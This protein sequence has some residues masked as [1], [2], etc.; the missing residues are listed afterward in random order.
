MNNSLVCTLRSFS[1]KSNFF[2][3]GTKEGK[4]QIINMMTGE[5]VKKLAVGSGSII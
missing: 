5:C 1:L 3:A 2:I 4:L